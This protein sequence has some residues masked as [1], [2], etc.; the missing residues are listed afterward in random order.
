MWWKVI[1]FIYTLGYLWAIQ[2][3]SHD[4][5]SFRMIT[6]AFLF[7]A[8]VGLFLFAF[9]RRFLPKLFWKVYTCLFAAY[10]SLPL[11]LGAKALINTSGI[12]I[13]A[14]IVVACAIFLVPIARSLWWLSFARTEPAST[15]SME[16]AAP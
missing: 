15:R 4:E 14:I 6:T 5:T 8:L 13:Y 1:A 10:W 2:D 12:L 11:I 3:A 7:P 16:I 9:D